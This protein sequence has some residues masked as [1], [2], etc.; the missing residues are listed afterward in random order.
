MLLGRRSRRRRC[1][2]VVVVGAPLD[3]PV[4]VRHRGLSK[5]S[6]DGGLLVAPEPGAVLFRRR[7]PS[8]EGLEEG[9]AMQVTPITQ[10]LTES[11]GEG[12]QVAS[13]VQR[14]QKISKK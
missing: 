5:D 12:G 7:Y 8:L 1:C 11:E 14:R 2:W 3:A 10:S 13:S 9:D 4:L 6:D